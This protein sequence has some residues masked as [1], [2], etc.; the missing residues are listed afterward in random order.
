[1]KKFCFVILDME[2]YRR[3]IIRVVVLLGSSENCELVGK[4]VSK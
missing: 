1:M 4:E 3:W 2:D